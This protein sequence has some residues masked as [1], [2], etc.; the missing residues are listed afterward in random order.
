MSGGGRPLLDQVL[1]KPR[2]PEKTGV[3]RERAGYGSPPA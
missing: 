2:Q 1:S 3:P